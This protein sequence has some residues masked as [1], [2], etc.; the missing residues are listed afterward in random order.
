MPNLG[1][2]NYARRPYL[3]GGMGSVLDRRDN[4][5]GSLRRFFNE[6]V[7]FLKQSN[8]VE[9][10]LE[11]PYKGADYRSMHFNIPGLEWPSW[12]FQP[13]DVRPRR[14]PP[15]PPF[16]WDYNPDD[17]ERLSGECDCCFFV[18]WNECDD[19]DA[20]GGQFFPIFKRHLFPGGSPVGRWHI[21]GNY[22]NFREYPPV[23]NANSTAGFAH[24]AYFDYDENQLTGDG[25]A[26]VTLCY[27]ITG[28]CF[29]CV[30]Y[31]APCVS[32]GCPPAVSISF[33]DASTPDTIA[34]GGTI[35][36]Y[37]LDG[38]PNFTWTFVGATFGY[39]FGSGTT[40]VR[41]NTIT[42][43]SGTCGTHYSEFCVVRVTDGC[44]EFVEF[45]IRNTG[46]QWTFACPNSHAQTT[47][48]S[49]SLCMGAA[50]I[51]SLTIGEERWLAWPVT[52]GSGSCNCT[53]IASNWTGWQLG[54][55]CVAPPISPFTF[56]STLH[57]GTG[58]CGTCADVNDGLDLYRMRYQKWTC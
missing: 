22:K 41:N 40:T 53:R 54:S 44:S 48:G 55:G 1:G 49:S 19:D 20:N 4:T 50:N 52:H 8:V 57:D 42:S 7:R 13:F 33:D 36:A 11:K 9:S 18:F 39:T 27:E 31:W 23:A 28:V 37:V 10:K 14:R 34:P 35:T 29:H 21:S 5:G 58:G 25:F 6:P 56:W 38:E 47:C 30:D 3:M 46:G 12:T 15:R 43:A 51:R 17:Y 45:T 32:A 2:R 16:P 26:F 24:A